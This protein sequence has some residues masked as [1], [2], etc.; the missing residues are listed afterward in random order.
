[1]I[2]YDEKWSKIGI[3]PFICYH[4]FLEK[5]F[6]NYN[7]LLSLP[8]HDLCQFQNS[9]QGKIQPRSEGELFVFNRRRHLWII[10][11]TVYYDSR[12]AEQKF[13]PAARG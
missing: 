8:N 7:Q 11:Q 1:M 12:A 2:N 6:C 4:W 13:V 5:P 3:K 10:Y 9:R